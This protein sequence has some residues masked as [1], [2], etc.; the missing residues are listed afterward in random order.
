MQNPNGKIT[1]PEYIKLKTLIS[2]LEAK[3]KYLNEDHSLEIQ[4]LKDL[5]KEKTSI[6]P[7]DND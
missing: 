3:Q 4:R 2:K 6:I 1:Q 7:L 5:L